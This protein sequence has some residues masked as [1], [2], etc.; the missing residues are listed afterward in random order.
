MLYRLREAE[1]SG[2]LKIEHIKKPPFIAEGGFCFVAF[3]AITA[4]SADP[5]ANRY[6]EPDYSL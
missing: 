4:Y 2:P 3:A 1:T 6:A 5:A